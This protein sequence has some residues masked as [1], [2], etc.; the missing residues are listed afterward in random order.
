MGNF[1]EAAR[2]AEEI[3][4][5]DPDNPDSWI[6]YEKSHEAAGMMDEA[7]EGRR[8]VQ[9]LSEVRAIGG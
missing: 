5:L 6:F 7:L 1:T 3:V 2:S 8:F 9:R 4:R